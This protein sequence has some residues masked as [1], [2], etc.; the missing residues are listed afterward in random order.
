M[1]CFDDLLSLAHSHPNFDDDNIAKIYKS[2]GRYLERIM[3]FSGALK[4]Y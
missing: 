1:Q 2:K 3:D 4:A